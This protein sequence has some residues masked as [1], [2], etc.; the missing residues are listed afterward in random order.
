MPELLDKKILKILD[1]SDF[2]SLDI[3]TTGLDY[4]KDDIIE[5]AAVHYQNGK[6]VEHINFFIRP[7]KAIPQNITRITG[8]TDADVANARPFAEVLPQ[9][10]SFTGDYPLIAHN[11]NFDLP[12]LEYHARKSNDNFVDW[13]NRKKEYHYFANRKIDTVI[14]ARL[15]LHFLPSSSLATLREYFQFKVDTAHRA[16]PDA[17]VTGK[18]FLEL[19]KIALR[20]KLADLQKIL[21]LLEPAGEPI[22][23]FFKK[24]ALLQASG[25]FKFAEGIDRESFAVNANYYNIIGEDETPSHKKFDLE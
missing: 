3:E 16:L 14:L 19:V 4:Q 12:F 13:N 5:F 17:E 21:K 20:T 9:I 1:I 6:A 7:T 22:F 11:V 25:K 23:D 18:I 10:Q 15:Y 8:I 2:I 24:L